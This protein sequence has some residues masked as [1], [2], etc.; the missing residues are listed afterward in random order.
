M[1]EV[2]DFFLNRG[3]WE[4]PE[5]PE[6]PNQRFLEKRE[7]RKRKEMEGKGMKRMEKEGKGRQRR[8]RKERAEKCRGSK[9]TQGK[10]KKRKKEE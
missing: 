5:L 2:D 4:I 8:K 9:E 10:A 6:T 7:G 3:A 1:R